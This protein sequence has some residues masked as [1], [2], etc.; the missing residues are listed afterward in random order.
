MESVEDRYTRT[1]SLIADLRRRA[2][3]CEDPREQTNLRRSVD[4]LVRVAL[5]LEP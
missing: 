3:A 4:S 1:Q 5:A 2:E